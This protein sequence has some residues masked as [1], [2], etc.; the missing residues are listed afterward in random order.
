MHSDSESPVGVSVGVQG[1]NPDNKAGEHLNMEIGERI[2][3]VRGDLKQDVFAQRL[4]IHKNT[5]GTYERGVRVPDATLLN[6]ICVEFGVSPT[7]LLLGQGPMHVNSQGLGHMRH[8]ERSI[9]VPDVTCLPGYEYVKKVRARL[10]AGSGSLLTSDEIE[11]YYAFRSD[12]LHRKGNPKTM[13]LMAVT[14]DSMAPEIMDEDTVLIDES[15]RDVYVGKK[16]AIAIDDEVYVKYIDREPGC[17]ILRSVNKDYSPIKVDLLDE[18]RD[19][20]VIGRM[21]WLGRVER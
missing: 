16:Y 8:G 9:E 15:Q 12:W 17:Y 10:S 7:W 21:I 4:G 1:S 20:R 13:V 6:R 18:S 14:G 3:L 19:V 2:K 5:V 11:G